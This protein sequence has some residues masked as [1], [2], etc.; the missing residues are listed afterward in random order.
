MTVSCSK[1]TYIRSL[2][3]DIGEKLGVFATM[4]SLKR[5][6]TSIFTEEDSI[7][8]NDLSE[9]NLLQN[10]IS[11]EEALAKYKPLKINEGFDKLLINGVRVMDKRLCSEKI[12]EDILYRVYSSTNSFLGLGQKDKNGF[13]IIKLLTH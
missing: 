8:I 2:C 9:E 10:M 5:S 1:G 12:E 6:K 4:T 7:N 3:Y 11:I 13:K